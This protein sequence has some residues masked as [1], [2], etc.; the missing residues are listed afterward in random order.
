MWMWGS[1]P[2]NRRV[3]NSVIMKTL[4]HKRRSIVA[5]SK[6][7][8]SRMDIVEDKSKCTILAGELALKLINV[9]PADRDASNIV[10]LFIIIVSTSMHVGLM[11]SCLLENNDVDAIANILV[12]SNGGMQVIDFFLC[13]LIRREIN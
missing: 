11:Y 1:R 6:F 12:F 2:G 10:C 3:V 4:R 7:F 8:K 5:R 9:H 13:E